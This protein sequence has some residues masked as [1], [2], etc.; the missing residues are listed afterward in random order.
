MGIM[1]MINDF[2][3]ASLFPILQKKG[4]KVATNNEYINRERSERER[5]IV[6]ENDILPM[7][8]QIHKKF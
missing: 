3:F 5:Q 6:R 1:E 2:F 4:G 7:K 8:I